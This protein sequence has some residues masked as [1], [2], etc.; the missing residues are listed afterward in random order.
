MAEK[1]KVGY[2][3]V[4]SLDQKT[5]RQLGRLEVA[6]LERIYEDK[7]SGS[8]PMNDRPNGRRLLADVREG[9]IHEIH[10][11]E[12]SR[13]GRDIKDITNVLYDL[14]GAGVQVVIHKEGLK[15][16]GD[17]GK[18]NPT[19]QLVLSVMSAIAMIERT[20]IRERCAEGLAVARAKGRLI[21]R[22]KGTSESPERFLAKPKSQK[23]LKFLKEGHGVTHAAK[24]AGVSNMTAM[25]VKKL[26][27]AA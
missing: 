8:V 11:T 3:R 25:K 15:L 24:L 10:F 26:T 7:C 17:D 5:D 20:A 12:V 14:I 18:P 9:R 6:G 21:G 27:M 23:V 19:A 22:K 2:A 16:L 1:L 13:I 4:S